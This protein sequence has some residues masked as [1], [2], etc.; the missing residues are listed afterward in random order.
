M[1][2]DQANELHQAYINSEWT[3]AAVQDLQARVTALEARW[4]QDAANEVHATYMA[5]HGIPH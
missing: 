2:Q 4:T 1:N 3:W 5:T